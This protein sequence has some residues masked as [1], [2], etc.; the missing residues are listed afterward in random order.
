M[1]IWTEAGYQDYR[2]KIKHMHDV[3]PGDAGK[4]YV[5]FTPEHDQFHFLFTETQA[6]LRWRR[7][8]AEARAK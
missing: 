4:P 5:E 1:P 6:Y 8:T 3:T 7:T 2:A